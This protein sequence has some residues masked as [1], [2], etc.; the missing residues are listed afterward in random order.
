[1]KLHELVIDL[2]SRFLDDRGQTTTEYAV[3]LAGIT[4]TSVF[5]ANGLSGQVANAVINVVRLLP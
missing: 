2:K 3:V 4:S 5:L 1:M